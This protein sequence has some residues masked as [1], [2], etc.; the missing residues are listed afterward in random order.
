MVENEI[1][2]IMLHLCIE[3][4]R[5]YDRDYV[6]GNILKHDNVHGRV[7]RSRGHGH[8]HIHGHRHIHGHADIFMGMLIGMVMLWELDMLSN[9]VMVMVCYLTWSWSCYLTRSCY[10][11]L[12]CSLKWSCYLA[13][14]R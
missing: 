8:W 14:S 7:S 2:T 4:I 11:R 9:M 10:Q 13:G 6:H 5:R 12:L 3:H 1:P